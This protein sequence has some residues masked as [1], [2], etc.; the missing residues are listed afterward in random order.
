MTAKKTAAKKSSTKK[1][2]VKKGSPSKG[3]AKKAVA[4]KTADKKQ[5]KKATSKKVGDI[6]VTKRADGSSSVR[7]GSGFIGNLPSAEAKAAP[8]ASRV[9]K[10]TRKSTS[11]DLDNIPTSS[12]SI[13]SAMVA[14]SNSLE[15]RLYQAT[16]S[17]HTPL[18]RGL[19]SDP[20][21]LVRATV[22]GNPYAH[23]VDLKSLL[24]SSDFLF[25]VIVAGNPNNTSENLH[26]LADAST[27]GSKRELD[28]LAEFGVEMRLVLAQIAVNKRTSKETLEFVFDYAKGRIGMEGISALV[29]SNLNADPDFLRRI[30]YEKDALLYSNQEILAIAGNPT[31]PIDVLESLSEDEDSSE[32]ILA[33]VA[34]NTKTEYSTLQKLE[35]NAPLGVREIAKH[36]RRHYDIEQNLHHCDDHCRYMANLIVERKNTLYSSFQKD[37]D[38]SVASIFGIFSGILSREVNSSGRKEE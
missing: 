9:A 38:E 28:L 35:Q 30:T 34:G 5:V 8:T 27:T 22:A 14:R 36:S 13:F 29:C 20:S 2:P 31:T 11:T 26:Q 7:Q 12:F 23:P 24:L 25:S 17:T 10:T 15:L 1:A 4:K 19:A 16:H 18:L 3:I 37:I 21:V 6:L 32:D 33:A